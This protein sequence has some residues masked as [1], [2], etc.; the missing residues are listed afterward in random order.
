MQTGTFNVTGQGFSGTPP[1][2]VAIYKLSTA[3]RLA[4]V[5]LPAI[6]GPSN[7]TSFS[8]TGLPA[9]LQPA[10]L[11]QQALIEGFDNGVEQG[12]LNTLIA[13]GSGTIIYQKNGSTTGWT[14]SGNK[15][16]G[17][18]IITLFLD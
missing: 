15:G 12:P 1:T 4:W 9:F 16:V 3:A 5:F 6:S 18:Q 10:T 8:I 17:I 2:G 13:P 11:T 14:A 7:S